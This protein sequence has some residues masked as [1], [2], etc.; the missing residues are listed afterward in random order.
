MLALLA[1]GL[2]GKSGGAMAAA[3]VITVAQRLFDGFRP[4]ESA[5]DFFECL[6]EEVNTVLC[7]TGMTSNLEPHTTLVMV[8]VQSGRMDWCHVGDSRLYQFRGPRLLHRTTDHTYAQRLID[9]GRFSAERARLHPSAGLLTQ[10]LGGKRRPAATHG[11][12]AEALAGDRFLLCSD[13][14]WAHFSD[15]ELA[16]VID[17]LPVREAAETLINGARIRAQGR[18][19]NCSLVLLSLMAGPMTPGAGS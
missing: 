15:D 17:N 1:D 13:G 9:S 16:T 14:L 6:L 3:E 18:G 10:A 8:L 11:G 2:G 7:L 4:G 5:R 19:D 12:T